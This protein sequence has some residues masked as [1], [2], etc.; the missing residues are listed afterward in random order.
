MLFKELDGELD[1]NDGIAITE[2][3]AAT[4]ESMDVITE[5]VV[6]NAF[7]AIDT[8]NSGNISKEE[9]EG[10]LGELGQQMGPGVVEKLR[11]AFE[12]DL[13]GDGEISFE[14]FME[15][16]RAPDKTPEEKAAEARLNRTPLGWLAKTCGLPVKALPGMKP[17]VSRA[18]TKAE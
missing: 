1:E 18:E 8:D 13:D 12:N 3:L 10:V 4:M 5:E 2:F 7:K 16:I 14:E 17:G 9:M 6:W 11:D 15:I